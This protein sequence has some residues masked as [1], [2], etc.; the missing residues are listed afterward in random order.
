LI[1]AF[2]ASGGG[3]GYPQGI[4]FDAS[5]NIYGAAAS[6]GAHNLGI[7][8]QL[9]PS[10]SGWVEHVLHAFSGLGDGSLPYGS[11][12]LDSAGNL[13]GT[14]SNGGAHGHGV[15]FE[16]K[17]Q[18]GGGWAETVL[19]SFTGGADGNS[20]TG[21]VTMDASGSLYGTTVY[22]GNTTS[23][24]CKL[25]GPGCGVA[26]KLTPTSTGWT[27]SLMHI[28]TG[29]NDG[30]NPGT[31]LIFDSAGNA[32]GAAAYGGNVST[33]PF[34]IGCG[35]VYKLTLGSNGKFTGSTLHRFTN[36]ADGS[37]PAAHLFLDGSGN[38]FGTAS[39]GASAACTPTGG[40]GT[41]FEISGAA[42]SQH[43]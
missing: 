41:V 4:V 21:G 30:A 33:C 20:P 23:T 27:E 35:T 38:L 8:Y 1:F 40:C 10:S 31:V 5:G 37:A 43:Q 18:T 34:S 42:A 29:G 36:K 28:F 16:L 13:Y 2:P 19:H 12:T 25:A 14:A 11:V 17:P 7:I 24:F 32:Y 39:A 15:V 9:T 3:G 22:G 26:F 6:N